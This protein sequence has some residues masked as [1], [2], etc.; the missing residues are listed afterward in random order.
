MDDEVAEPAPWEGDP[1]AYSWKEVDDPNILADALNIDMYKTPA[2]RDQ[3]GRILRLFRT[4]H[5]A[6]AALDALFESR[7]LDVTISYSADDDVRNSNRW[8][9]ER[10]H[11]EVD[12]AGRDWNGDD[13]EGI[14][15]GKTLPVAIAH[16]LM[17]WEGQ[18]PPMP[19]LRPI[20]TPKVGEHFVVEG[21]CVGDDTDEMELSPILRHCSDRHV[22][23]TV[24][25]LPDP[26][27][28]SLDGAT[29]DAAD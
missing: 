23:I 25:V 9:M 5:S 26:P 18:K 6:D 4:F 16:A 10:G 7:A 8:F 3:F 12:I 11:W 29:Y 21:L 19:E 22:R 15:E 14:G 13:W 20:P 24:E 1:R 28:P 17:C 2:P 27:L